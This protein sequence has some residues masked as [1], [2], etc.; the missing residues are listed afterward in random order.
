M[1]KWEHLTVVI[2]F[3]HQNGKIKNTLSNGVTTEYQPEERPTIN[4]YL[5]ILAEESWELVGIIGTDTYLF[6]RR[7]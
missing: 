3:N 6:S 5:T 7:R 1:A 4:E 2:Q